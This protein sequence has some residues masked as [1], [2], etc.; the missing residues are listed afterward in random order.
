MA[1]NQAVFDAA[2][3][4]AQGYAFENQWDRALKEYQRAIAEFPNDGQARQNYAQALYRLQ[5]Y[6]QALEEYTGLLKVHPSDPFLLNRLAEINVAMGR[7]A[8]ARH[9]LPATGPGLFGPEPDPRGDRGVPGADRNRADPP[10]CAGA[11]GG[12]AQGQRRPGG[13]D[14]RAGHAVADGYR[15]PARRPGRR[16]QVCRGGVRPRREPPRRPRMA[17]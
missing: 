2:M 3:R 14:Q 5:Q 9:L 11:A 1:G 7:R 16:G 6:P 15:R 8:D 4:R 10:R 13:G 12:V 17:L